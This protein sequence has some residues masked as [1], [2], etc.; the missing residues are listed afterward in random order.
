[1]TNPDTIARLW[2]EGRTYT[3]IAELL[4]TT[5]GTVAGRVRRMGLR[6]RDPS[7]KFHVR[8]SEAD[9]ARMR[10][11]S[12][13]GKSLRE[14]ARIMKIGGH[15]TVA[16][17]VSPVLLTPDARK[18][19][20]TQESPA[21]PDPHV[22]AGSQRHIA[23]SRQVEWLGRSKISR[24]PV[25]LGP[26]PS[27]CQYPQGDGPYT[28]CADPVHPG[29]PYCMEHTIRCYE[30]PKPIKIVPAGSKEPAYHNWGKW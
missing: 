15:K 11:L 10:Q 18:S 5:P 27:K 19:P 25:H 20:S 6:R 17:Y 30:K 22:P 2:N 9:I 3:Q 16:R 21:G 24:Q 12:V 26:P 14:I 4:S 13:E 7:S 23:K 28:F 1:L 8:Y 29:R